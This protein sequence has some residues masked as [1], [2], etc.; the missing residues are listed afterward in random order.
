MAF[1]TA[2]NPETGERVVFINNAWQP[3]A[4]SATNPDSGGKAYLINNSWVTDTVAAPPPAEVQKGPKVLGED[5]TSSDFARALGNY[6]GQAQSLM[7]SGQALMGLAAKKMGFEETGKSQIEKGLAR[8]EEGERKTVSKKSDEFT[9]ALDQGIGTVLT[10]WL[11]YQVGA[12]VGN[13]LE[14]LAFAGAGAG[15]GAVTGFGAGAVPAAAAGFVSKTLVKSGIKEAAENVLKGTVAKEIA[16]GATKAAAKE[17][18]QLAS[19]EFIENETKKVIVSTVGKEAF[20]EGAQAYGK[21]GAKKVGSY[22]GTGTQAVGHGVGEVGGRAIQEGQER[23]ESIDDIDLG[24]VLP[25]ATIHTVADFINNRIGLGALKI[26]DATAKSM[27]GEIGKRYGVTLLKEIPGEEIQAVAE[28]Y[29]AK[30]NL[31]DADALKE[32]LNTAA[33][34]AAMVVAPSAVGGA[35]TRL[36]QNIRDTSENEKAADA[37]YE[38]QKE[39]TDTLES[40]KA[41]LRTEID[42]NLERDL[43]PPTLVTDTDTSIPPPAPN[44]SGFNDAQQK[45]FDYVSAIPVGGEADY[46]KD[47]TKNKRVEASQIRGMLSDLGVEMPKSVKGESVRVQGVTALRQYFDNIQTPPAPPTDVAP[48]AP[49]TDV[50]PPTPPTDVAPPVITGTD[51]TLSIPGQT[52]AVVIPPAVQKKYDTLQK[53]SITPTAQVEIAKIKT[54]YPGITPTRT[55]SSKAQDTVVEPGSVSF[56]A[57]PRQFPGPAY[58]DPL[59]AVSFG[60]YVKQAESFPQNQKQEQEQEQE[61]GVYSGATFKGKTT[62]VETGPV[63]LAPKSEP[64]KYPVYTYIEGLS[65]KVNSQIEKETLQ[66]YEKTL[67]EYE[68]AQDKDRIEKLAQSKEKK[69]WNYDISDP[70]RVNYNTVSTEHNAEAEAKNDERATL[71]AAVDKAKTKEEI[72]DAKDNLAKHGPNI[73][74]LPQWG[75]NFSAAEKDIYFGQIKSGDIEEHRAA[76]KALLDYFS[77]AGSKEDAK[78]RLA[79]AYEENRSIY[80]REYRIKFPEWRNLTETAKTILDN[81]TNNLA[82]L[83]LDVGFADLARHYIAIDKNKTNKEKI[84]IV[85]NIVK[86]QQRIERERSR[87]VEVLQPNAFNT[88]T[89]TTAVENTLDALIKESDRAANLDRLYSLK[90]NSGQ[91]T[92]LTKIL[93]NTGQGVN[94]LQ[95]ALL[96]ISKSRI[97]SKFNRL[98][99]GVI[100]KMGLTTKIEIVKTLPDNDQAIYNPVEDRIYIRDVNPIVILHEAIHAITVKVLNIYTAGDRSQ[101]TSTQIKAVEQ[102][103]AIMNATKNISL[104]TGNKKNPYITFGE[105]YKNAYENIFEFVSYSLTSNQFQTDLEDADSGQLVSAV[106]RV[107]LAVEKQ[108]PLG[109][110]LPQKQ[111]MWSEFKK[112]IADILI[113]GFKVITNKNKFERKEIQSEEPQSLKQALFEY[114][115]GE[116]NPNVEQNFLMEIAASFEDILAVPPK[117]GVDLNYLAPKQNTNVTLSAKAP[118]IIKAPDFTKGIGKNVAP[119]SV[120]Q[121]IKNYVFTEKGHVR[122]QQIFQDFRAPLSLLQTRLANSNLI[123]RTGANINDIY[124]EITTAVAIAKNYFHAY[125]QEPVEKLNEAVAKFATASGLETTEALAE[126]HKFLLAIHSPERR[127]VNFILNVPLSNALNFKDSAGNLMSVADRRTAIIKLLNTRTLTKGEAIKLRAELNGYVFDLDASGK[128]QLDA[129]GNALINKKYVDP[130]GKNSKNSIKPGKTK[131]DLPVNVPQSISME[132]EAY[133]AAGLSVAYEKEYLKEYETHKNKAEI[134]E[135]IPLMQELHKQT[136]ILNKKGNFWSQPVSNRVMFYGWD[137]YIP[138]KGKPDDDLDFNGMATNRT[139][140]KEHQEVTAEMQGRESIGD[141]PILQTAYDAVRSTIRASQP[142]LMLAIQNNLDKGRYNPNGQG[143]IKGIVEQHITF[144]ERT[145]IDMGLLKGG[146]RMLKYNSDGSIDVLIVNDERYRDSIRK[147]YE[148]SQP[149][150]DLANKV[151]GAIAQG[152]T[153]YNYNFA[154]LNFVRDA[155]TNSFIIGADLGP[156]KAIKFLSAVSRIV[157][158]NGMYKALQVAFV[159]DSSK[160]K[161]IAKLKSLTDPVTGS[162]FSR[163]MVEY[164]QGGG[165][166]SHLSGLSMKSALQEVYDKT[167]RTGILKTKDQIDKFVDTWTNMFELTS[168]TAA[169]IVAKEHYLAINNKNS[170][171]SP[172]TA[173]AEAVRGA[174][175][176][177]KNLANFEQVGEAGKKMGALFMFFRPSATGAVRAM[178]AVAPAFNFYKDMTNNLPDV[179]KNN[180]VALA[181]YKATYAQRQK[182]ARI[183]VAS[184]IGLGFMAHTMAKMMAPDDDQGRNAIDTDDM[185]RWTR[186]ARIHIPDGLSESLNLGKNVIFQIP[187]GF[188]FGA[189]AA[190]GAQMSAMYDGT[191]SVRKGLTNIATSI[192]LDSFVPLPISKI[193]ATEM[194]GAFVLDSIT[195]SVIRPVLGFV[196]NLNGLGQNIHN[197]ANRRMGDAYTGGDNIPE[198]YKDA[199][200]GIANYS[201]GSDILPILDWSPNSLYFLANSY[202]DGVARIAETTYGITNLAEGR[203]EF[204]P[205]TD[206]PLMGSFFGSK[207]NI[208]AQRFDKAEQEIKQIA[209]YIKQ[210]DSDSEQGDKYDNKYPFHRGLVEYYDSEVQGKL[211]DLRAEANVVRLDT[212]LS[213]RQR[214]ME[215]K[216]IT[217]EANVIKNDMLENFK[218]YGIKVK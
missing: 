64:P 90:E 85:K 156:T 143:I 144:E 209:G 135:I 13:I 99:A 5:D 20:A 11:P 131:A 34:T 145:Q 40:E 65:D 118:K 202:L 31:T 98:I 29:G 179:I 196:M 14:S 157:A 47:S 161:D 12:G 62:P 81:S 92:N 170:K 207:V 32:Y 154:P 184:L 109:S 105:K 188:G 111:S 204:S 199:A 22:V 169:F 125:I 69:N 10:D 23:G 217:M 19:K 36:A 51:E 45:A 108:K 71:I 42:P 211:K 178:Q 70:D 129:Q 197:E 58:G 136:T 122:L 198:I 1:P 166:V 119:P 172:E 194:P 191:T 186:F 87:K 141:N 80:A 213:P 187:W 195:P 137:N 49:P 100:Y 120:Y 192:A 2:T 121:T 82:G 114:K 133:D 28:R 171:M 139:G 89:I 112:A 9:A 26:G 163:D 127:L 212:S 76:A 140:G 113:A 150:W 67:R 8:M 155:L 216:M 41:A 68:G 93:E 39:I 205:K 75:N 193:P 174:I 46:F 95:D 159:F 160:P 176:F 183:M 134:D 60:S 218:E 115:K 74:Y 146:V 43:R 164:I 130:L 50:A 84:D 206:L 168:R 96:F 48:P 147:T 215:L 44:V 63:T 117:G 103:I 16:E 152:H 66:E 88:P 210:F 185:D 37:L 35:R 175:V 158:T 190:A 18:G 77:R 149:L 214:A 208:D 126:L 78:T 106:S 173:Y 83:Q 128:I 21:A 15:I 124:G 148:Q 162:Q 107:A 181:E 53:Y 79:S 86:V 17:A 25:A 27:I 91:K 6:P 24:R 153:R 59:L 38:R 3:F 116:L 104:D 57:A 33:A 165:M 73:D 54:D 167:N 142:N 61:S 180:P 201:V 203:K 177:A 102:L 151:T 56:T 55:L 72:K 94:N 101:L 7:G 110:V 200:R 30:L 4:Q 189:F 132:D 182:N 97:T 52:N 123:Q 138:L